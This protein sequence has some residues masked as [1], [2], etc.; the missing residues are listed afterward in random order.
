MDSAKTSIA[1][2]SERFGVCLFFKKGDMPN[3]FSQIIK[4]V[5]F[6]QN[7]SGKHFIISNG[8]SWYLE[9]CHI[10]PNV[11]HVPA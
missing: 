6:S 8:V 2:W 1:F 11:M 5:C 3:P 10:R 4:S 7:L 9:S